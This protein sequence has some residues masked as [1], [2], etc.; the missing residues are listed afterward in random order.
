MVGRKKEITELVELYESNKSE[1]VAV[2]GRRRVGKTY[3]IDEVFKDKITFRHAG[4]SPIEEDEATKGSPLKKQLQAFYYSLLTQGMKKSSCPKDW[5]EAF[6]M[7]EMHLQSFDDGS[8]QIV[9]LDEL[10]WMDTPKSGFITAFEAFWNGWACHRNVMVIISGSAT[11]WIKDKLINNHGGL[12]GRV[13]YEIKLL[14]FSLK[15]CE[16]LFKE[17]GINL[18]RYD[19]VQSYMIFGGIPF[20][21]NYFGRGKSLAQNVDELFFL[22]GARL[23]QEFDRLFSSIFNNPQMMKTIV[24]VL[25]TRSRGF[26]RK[27]I[28]EQTGYS[29][30]GTLTEALKSLAA[31]DFILKYIPFGYS[32]REI[33][34]KLIDPFCIFYIKF[35]EAFKSLPDSFWQQNCSSQIVVSWRGYA[36]ENICF[37][38]IEQIK[39][40]L[41]ISA[42]SSEQSAWIKRDGDERGTQIDL[43]ISRKDN[44]IN[45]CELKFY[46]DVFTV[47]KEYDLLLRHRQKLLFELVSKKKTIHNTLITTYGIKDN[48]YRW[49]FDNVIVMDDLF[50]A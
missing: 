38:H 32:K 49:S 22:K 48:S 50:E 3:L 18:S 33:H 6:Y 43:L 4:L 2:Y 8:R 25:S 34:Y 21:L 30:G 45:L 7:L 24:K 23:N 35:V 47:D 19:I 5:L 15:E 26:T 1:L 36:F 12:Y 27:E 46:S 11:S 10:P 28:S 39:N 17:R 20:Y 16:L 14:P 44:V 29:D 41:G 42:V 9:F 31:S 13:T 40:K 37:N